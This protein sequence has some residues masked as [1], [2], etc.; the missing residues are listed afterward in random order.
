MVS[1]PNAELIRRGLGRDDLFTVVH[2]QFLTDTARWADIVLPATTQIESTD[3]VQAWGHLNLGWNEAAIA[4]VGQSVSN[5]EL[6]RRLAGAMGWTEPELFEDDM[7]A[8]KAA[9]PTVD[10]DALRRDGFVRV[11]YPEDGRPWGDGVFP[12]RSGK[13]ELVSSLLDALGHPSLPTYTP[14]RESLQGGGDTPGRPFQLMTPKHHTRFLNS[15]YSHLPK[16]GPL[17]GAPFLEMCPTDAE[18]LGL[19][20]GSTARVHNDRASLELPVRVTDRLQPGLVVI[21]WGWWT[22]QHADGRAANALTTDT[23]TDWGG[24][25]AFS[26]TLV[27]ID[28]C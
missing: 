19:A 13:V 2:D 7:T 14:A 23:L 10:L 3:V 26:D 25:V 12:T 9:L 24:G 22:S 28:A 6:F 15:S 4:P 20:D 21:P 11:P 17:E 8:L 5:S 1:T 18:R 16:H 27:S